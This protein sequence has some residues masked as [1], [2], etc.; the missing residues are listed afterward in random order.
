MTRGTRHCHYFCAFSYSAASLSLEGESLRGK[1]YLELIGD[2]GPRRT[3]FEL[4]DRLLQRVMWARLPVNFWDRN[5]PG[6]WFL[7]PADFSPD[8]VKDTLDTLN[9]KST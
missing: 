4:Q 2:A 8:D 1:S 6:G 3:T 7:L 5:T 9:N